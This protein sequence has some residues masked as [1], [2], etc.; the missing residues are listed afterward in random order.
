MKIL[1]RLIVIVLLFS[2][3][4][5]TQ[6]VT[7]SVLQPAPVTLPAYVKNVAVVN[8]TTPSQKVKIVNVVNKILS[9]EG[10]A[11]DKE[12]SKAATTALADELSKNAHL[13][14]VTI[15]ENSNLTTDVPGSFPA[16]LSWDEVEKYCSANNADALFSLEIFDTKSNIDYTASQTAVKTPLGNVPAFEQT[17]N[18]HTSVTTGWRIYDVRS[19]NI[20]DEIAFSRMLVF[21]GKGINPLL[22][23]NA[24]IGRKEAVKQVGNLAGYDY[25]FSIVPLWTRVSRDYYIKGNNNFTMATRKARTGNW[26]GAANLWEQEVDNPKS[27]IAGR[28][29]YNMAIICEINGD[30]DGAIKWAQKSYEDFGNHLALKYVKILNNRKLDNEILKDQ[31]VDDINKYTSK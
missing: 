17:A 11:L 25:A 3:C 29:C 24:L 13:D 31:Q 4:S 15:I 7:I 22:A 23:A 19:K 30:L 2:S 5:S 9:A 1:F 21:H 8:R 16:L 26:E 14:S 20:L 12:G 6:L 18:M 10:T 27:K 28:A